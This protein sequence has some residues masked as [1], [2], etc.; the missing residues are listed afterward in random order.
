[1]VN[2]VKCQIHNSPYFTFFAI[3]S[4]CHNNQMKTK[5]ILKIVIVG[6]SDTGKTALTVR[7]VNGVFDPGTTPTIGVANFNKIVKIEDREYDVSLWDTAGSEKYRGLTPNY[8]RKA[9]GAIVV[10][11]VNNSSSFNSVIRW[12]SDVQN[13]SNAQIVVCG[14]KID[15]S[16][17]H[18]EVTTAEISK[19]TKMIGIPYVETS[20]LSG[21]GVFQLFESLYKEINLRDSP[22]SQISDENMKS[23]T[24]S[25]NPQKEGCC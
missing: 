17:H 8:Y 1:M 22:K 19:L 15:I 13:Y 12:I 3:T 6:D 11:D 2:N 9:D 14:N 7:Y 24:T 4:Q 25:E 20:A 18:R 23:T 16:D 5:N 10:F 21:V